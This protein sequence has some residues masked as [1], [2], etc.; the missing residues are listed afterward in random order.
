MT[1][2]ISSLHRRARESSS[3]VLLPEGEDVRIL[4]AAERIAA[5][6]LARPIVIAGETTRQLCADEG[7]AVDG[8]EF[9]RLNAGSEYTDR[10]VELRD[11]DPTVAHEMLSDKLI[12]GALLLRLEEVAGLVAGADTPTA[13]V[14]SAANGIVG[15]SD[16]INT[17]SSFF[18]M[19]FDDVTIGE[20]GA[21]L[22]A[23][24]GVN[25]DPTVEQLADIATS[26]AKTARTLMN[27]T[28]RVAMLS[29]STKGSAAHDDAER[30]ARAAKLA[31]GKMPDIIIDGE[32][33][34][35]VALVK[36]VAEHKLSGDGSVVGD[37]NV[38]IFPD[39]SSG[40]IAYKLMERL[41]GARALGPILQGYAR[42]VSDLSRGAD[43]DDIVDI[44]A[45]TAVRS[46]EGNW[47]GGDIIP[48]GMIGRRE[49]QL[50]SGAANSESGTADRASR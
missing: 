30:M 24:C 15:L 37:A 3:R 31:S 11:V 50:S 26:S 12:F 35:D 34:A 25:I 43:V 33:Q 32:L 47:R 8:I 27:W 41:G 46:A 4:R 45:L 9:R 36:E 49:A 39:L 17:G 10:Y 13:E 48:G 1:D 29:F 6:G 5:E 44:T 40:N 22:F 28:P 38:L 2:I 7:I 23:D 21:L 19:V 14:V 18:L 20:N 42:P 16:G